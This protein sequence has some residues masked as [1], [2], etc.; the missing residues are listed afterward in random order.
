MIPRV[1]KM[2][3]AITALGD[4]IVKHFPS[5]SHRSAMPIEYLLH[6]TKTICLL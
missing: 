4:L 6:E 2:R 3:D 1:K 5:S